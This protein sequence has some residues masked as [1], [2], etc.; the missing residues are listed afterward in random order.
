MTAALCPWDKEPIPAGARRDSVYCS[1]RCRQ[2]AWRFNTQIG[3]GQR[4]PET[5]LRLGYA[6]PPYPGLSKRYYADH[7]DYD[8]E[9]DHAALI[10]RL[11]SEFD[12]WALSTNASSLQALLALCPPGVR[13]AAWHRGARYVRSL[14]PL[15]AWEP[16]IYSGGRLAIDLA[17]ITEAS[18][19]DPETSSGRT[20]RR[21][22]SAAE[23]PPDSPSLIWGQTAR[24]SDVD[25]VV[26][27]KPAAYIRFV[28]DL[29]GARPQD[30]F[31]DL[32]P[33]SGGFTRAWSIYSGAPLELDLASA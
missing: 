33:G 1:K 29:L 18:E 23:T 8:G 26:G 17:P 3:V 22:D 10:R 27:S 30:E 9:V 4:S 12:G 24:L 7:P 16:I 11:S 15:S 13:I 19:V 21:I 5:P 31:V 25:R 28:F 14:G 6:D 32:F 20:A 2:A